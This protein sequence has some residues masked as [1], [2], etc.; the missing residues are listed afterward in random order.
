MQRDVV[1]DVASELFLTRGYRATTVG[2]IAESAGIGTATLFRYFRSKEGVLAALSRRDI[3]LT[4]ANARRAAANPPEDPA[5][6]ML[7]VFAEILEMHALPST[8][9]RGQT[10]IWLL[11]PT[12]HPET[13]EVVT[14]SDRELQDLIR[15][16]LQRYQREGRLGS[17][18]DLDDATA[19]IFAVFYHHYMSIA[20]DRTVRLQDVTAQLQRRI[21]LLF[22]AWDQAPSPSQAKARK[23]DR[24]TQRL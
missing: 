2:A 13:D 3:D 15:S 10:R 23:A 22:S 11:I 5:A 4:L 6:A 19:V 17:R 18:L 8:Q 24:K 20:L 12:G 16:L 1:L 9:I 7:A 21:P 14:S